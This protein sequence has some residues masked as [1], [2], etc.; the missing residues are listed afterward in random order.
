[1]VLSEACTTLPVTEAATALVAALVAVLGTLTAKHRPAGA[2]T[3]RS[4]ELA[5]DDL[6]LEPD[7]W[8]V[9]DWETGPQPPVSPPEPRI[10][11][12]RAATRALRGL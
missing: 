3:R 7:D 11:R 12:I 2:R 6:E 5:D 9:E 1:M 4:D 8:G 10:G